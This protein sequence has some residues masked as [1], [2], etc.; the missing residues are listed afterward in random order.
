MREKTK[1]AKAIVFEKNHNNTSKHKTR[2][3]PFALLTKFI[4]NESKLEF[5]S[6]FVV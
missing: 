5:T 4:V 2:V 1:K 3:V 6:G